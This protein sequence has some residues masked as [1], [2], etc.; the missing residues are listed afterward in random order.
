MG[1]KRG[2]KEWEEMRFWRVLY[3][4]YYVVFEG[5]NV[6]HHC[7]GEDIALEERCPNCGVY[8]NG[9]LLGVDGK[10]VWKGET[11]WKNHAKNLRFIKEPTG[12]GKYR[13][14]KSRRS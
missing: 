2:S 8:I 6:V 5:S 1:A 9:L 11:R 13:F 14:C 12:R 4:E 10:E 3:A 7:T